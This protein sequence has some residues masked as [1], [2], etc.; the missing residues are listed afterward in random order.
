MSS[1]RGTAESW[2]QREVHERREL[3]VEGDRRSGEASRLTTATLPPSPNGGTG[4]LG[5]AM[6]TCAVSFR[7]ALVASVVI[8]GSAMAETI[9]FD[10]DTVGALPNGWIAGVTGGG[11]S[12][13]IVEA[14]QSAPSKPNV[15]KQSGRGAFP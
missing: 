10:A 12:R 3:R 6:N 7:F 14:D 9:N 4:F 15:L 11:S 5:I 13:W 2:I 8:G 1:R